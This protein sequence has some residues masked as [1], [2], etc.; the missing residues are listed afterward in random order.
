MMPAPA[1]R[2]SCRALYLWKARPVAHTLERD[3]YALKEWLRDAWRQ[4]AESSI[5]RFERRELRNLMKQTDAEL[6]ACLEILAATDRARRES[7]HA[8]PPSTREPDF[9]IL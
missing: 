5:T 4:L 9:R 3:V 2:I 1:N 6:R 8:A 7:R